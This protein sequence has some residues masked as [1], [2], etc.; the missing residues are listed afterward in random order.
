ME[1]KIQT[2][3]PPDKKKSVTATYVAVTLSRLTAKDI[4]VL[5][6]ASG[7]LPS[8]FFERLIEDLPSIEP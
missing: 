4:V 7:K 3:A 5:A 2:P 1:A 8:E 6:A